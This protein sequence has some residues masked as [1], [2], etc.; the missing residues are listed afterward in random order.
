MRRERRALAAGAAGLTIVA[1]VVAV[2]TGGGGKVPGGGETRT[3]GDALADPVPYDG[4]SPAQPAARRERVL[5]ELPRPALGTRADAPSLSPRRQRA[6]VRSLRQESS[7]LLSALEA[8][9][10]KLRRVVTFER[11]WHGFAATVGA[12]D[13]PGL[14]S[15]GVRVRANRRFF[16]AFS[17]PVRVGA[18]KPVPPA[19]DTAPRVA[20]LAG[21]ARGGPLAEAL[22]ALGVRV[23]AIRVTS[24]VAG[25]E[26]G[27][28]D[29]LLT[30][31]ER[32]VDPDLD[33]N[34]SDHD[35]VALA[36]VSAPYAGFADAPEAEAMAG[37]LGL[38]TLV[39]TP[40]G[41]EGAAAGAYGTVGSPG[42]APGALSVAALSDPAAVARARLVV[43]NTTVTGA[44][45]LAGTPGRGALSTA[46]PVAAATA[47]ALLAEG[48]PP[49]Q[50][51]LAIVRAG[52]NPGA[53]AAA[54]A[55]VGAAAVLLAEPRAGRPLATIPAGRLA[56]PVLGI[57]GPAAAAVLALDPGLPAT[58][59]SAAAPPAATPGR[60]LG[61]GAVSRFS[62]AGPAYDGSD[63]PE[64][65]R[66]GSVMAGG[67]LVAGGAVA[68]A[69]VAA[70]AA[71]R[72]N[73]DP[74]AVR[75]E[76]LAPTQ[77]ARDAARARRPVPPAPSVP[78]GPVEVKRTRGATSVELTVGRFDRGDPPAGRG[79]ESVPADRLQ[80][81]LLGPGT[82]E[83]LTP[84]GGQRGVLPGVYAYTLPRRVLAALEAG[85][86]LFK[87]RARA[88]RQT[89]PTLAQSAPFRIG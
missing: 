77:A 1:V 22:A 89:A 39:V 48:S 46:G 59:A 63:K 41:H 37:A 54:A 81:T 74:E 70:E 73:P 51:R 8:R 13:I 79:T 35:R 66:P 68:A 78:V 28:T 24:L 71:K 26:F 12:K 4:R 40:A 38:G 6:Y 36:A 25:E 62:S 31:L 9:G 58:I 44:A 3:F 84:P 32:T 2:A 33:G 57:T 10:V 60:V 75:A 87:V 11:T 82:R 7:A 86:Y 14:Q 56:I 42:A 80:L 61:A 65:F 85:S 15:L 23:R 45:V 43:G 50:G 21:G 88:P 17:A 47:T 5:V 34:T 30:G 76:L 72:P 67:D 18:R 83:T 53:Q 64:L 55:A 52:A 29:Q 69:Q 27:R 49:L 20:L 16:P 19:P